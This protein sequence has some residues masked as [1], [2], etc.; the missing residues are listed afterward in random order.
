VLAQHLGDDVK[1]VIAASAFAVACAAPRAPPSPPPAVDIAPAAAESEPEPDPPAEVGPTEFPDAAAPA[2]TGP[3]VDTL[4]R[5]TESTGGATL[6]SMTVGTCSPPC[7]RTVHGEYFSRTAGT[8][9]DRL[10]RL[11]RAANQLDLELVE[12]TP[13]QDDSLHVILKCVES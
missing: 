10:T 7:L 12:W 8:F 6:V 3:C 4:K 5:W 13:H 2:I 9:P 1:R 11:Q